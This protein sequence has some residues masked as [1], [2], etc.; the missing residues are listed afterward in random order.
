MFERF[1]DQAIKA[2]TLAQDES[3]RLKLSVVGSEQLLLGVLGVANG[4]SRDVLRVHKIS[5]KDAR[6]DVE[7]IKGKGHGRPPKEMPFTFN[8][9]KA[10]DHAWTFAQ[11]FNT[12][13]VTVDH[14]FLGILSTDCVATQV[15]KRLQADPKLLNED[16]FTRLQRPDLIA[17]STAL[18]MFG[19]PITQISHY[20]SEV[21]KIS[22]H[23]SKLTETLEDFAAEHKPDG[24]KTTAE[25]R[26]AAQNLAAE[27][28]LLETVI[29]QEG[30][31]LRE[32]L[33]QL[34]KQLRDIHSPN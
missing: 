13:A 26:E 28:E 15:L 16:M 32:T 6:N 9:Q 7:N 34:K 17:K 20:R 12:E 23:L 33:A 4:A 21:G 1:T 25:D 14:V 27:L 10:L 11:V 18:L 24:K 2:V 3:R 19:A 31:T 8:A 5:L 30:G 22:N 29:E